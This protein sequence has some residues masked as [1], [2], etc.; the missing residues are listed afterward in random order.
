MNATVVVIWASMS[1]A[2]LGQVLAGTPTAAPGSPVMEASDAF[3]ALSVADARATAKWYGE[4]LGLSVVQDLP[5]QGKAFAIILEGG[6]LIVELIQDDD[7]RPL[8]AVAPGVSERIGVHG[9]VKA[10]AVV[11]DFEKTLAMLRQRNVAIAYGPY[12]ARA[13]QRANVI[14]RDYEGNLIQF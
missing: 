6:G 10:G 11:S 13:G 8:S 14:V 1:M 9:L 5:K 3:F 7:A 2:S 12:P 4:K